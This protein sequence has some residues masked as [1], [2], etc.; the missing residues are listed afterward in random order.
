MGTRQ[1]A[2]DKYTV[3]CLRCKQEYVDSHG[4]NR[5]RWYRGECP[6]CGWIRVPWN[7]GVRDF[8][9]FEQFLEAL[10]LHKVDIST[11]YSKLRRPHVW[12]RDLANVMES[13]IFFCL[14]QSRRNC[15]IKLARANDVVHVFFG[16]RDRSSGDFVDIAPSSTRVQIPNFYAMYNKYGPRS[17]NPDGLMVF[18]GSDDNEYVLASRQVFDTY[19]DAKPFVNGI[20]D[21]RDPI[22]IPRREILKAATEARPQQ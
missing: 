20:S 8:P 18:C 2:E 5:R 19:E 12:L 13:E 15:K 6:E 1:K 11:M 10:L 21:S 7:N 3:K 4:G 14:P 9:N 16:E 22:V 17:P